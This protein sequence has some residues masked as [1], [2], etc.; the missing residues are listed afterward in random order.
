MIYIINE[1]A[2]MQKYDTPYLSPYAP[3]T[4]EDLKDGIL[5]QPFY[6][7]K[8]RPKSL[9]YKNKIRIEDERND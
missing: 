1:L 4:P 3:R 8:T 5:M 7:M 6:Q 9:I 2:T